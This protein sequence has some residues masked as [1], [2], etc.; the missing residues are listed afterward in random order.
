MKKQF[1][2]LLQWKEKVNN[3]NKQNLL[4]FE[5]LHRQINLLKLENEKYKQALESPDKQ[6]NNT[7]SITYI[8]HISWYA[9]V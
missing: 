5:H 9:S 4:R 8:E 7:C 3:S 1:Q 6:V 2:M